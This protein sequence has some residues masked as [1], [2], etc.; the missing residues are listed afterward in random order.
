[1][2]TFLA[3]SGICVACYVLVRIF[4]PRYGAIRGC[5]GAGPAVEAA[6]EEEK[7]REAAARCASK[8]EDGKPQA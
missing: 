4:K 2:S 6:M 1:M 5:C 3:L 7:K 8:P